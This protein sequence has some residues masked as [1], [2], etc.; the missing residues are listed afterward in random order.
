MTS[1]LKTVKIICFYSSWVFLTGFLEQSASKRTK[2][3]VTQ[4][5]AQTSNSSVCWKQGQCLCVYERPHTDMRVECE[6][7]F[8]DACPSQCRAFWLNSTTENTVL[9]KKNSSNGLARF[10]VWGLELLL[11]K[12]HWNLWG[13][14]AS[15]FKGFT[16][17]F[18]SAF[19]GVKLWCLLLRS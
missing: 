16:F 9:K 19:E 2:K 17:Y 3:K 6:C 5:K 11:L 15:N 10:F 8:T 14:S 13:S 1:Q 7:I 4:T 12:T 18:L